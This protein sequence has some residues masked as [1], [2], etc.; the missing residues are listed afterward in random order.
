MQ[1]EEKT[2]MFYNDYALTILL[3]LFVAVI[4]IFIQ[5]FFKKYLESD[6]YYY[7]KDITL[8]AAWALCGIWASDRSL[9]IT[10]AAG[11]AA[12]CVGF[13][14]KVTKGKNL[15]FLYFIVGLGFSLFGPRIAFIEFAQGEYYYLTYFASIA[16]STLWI[17]I[18]PIFFQ[19]ID[20]IPGMCGL[21]LTVSWTLVSIVIMLSSQNLREAVQLCLIGMV[22]IL[23]FWSR[24]IHAYRRLTEPLTALWGTLFAGLSIFGV[25][26][27]VAFYTLAALP[28]GLF[29]IP[30]IETS[31]SVVS[32][33]F[34]PKPT[35]NLILYRK[36]LSKG[37]DHATAVHT[38]VV[39]CAL[40]GCSAAFIQIG[41]ANSLVLLTAAVFIF[42]ITWLFFRYAS[43][44]VRSQSRRPGLWGIR[45]D[46]ISLNY[47]ITQ[48]Q[49]SI[50][51]GTE[52][53]MIVTPDALAALR[54]RTDERY[55]NIV[56][57]ADLVLPDGAGLIAA[58]KILHTP[59]QERIP[60]VEFTE[61]ICKRAAYEGWGIWF[62]G[63]GPGTAEAAA[64]KLAEKYQGLKIAGTRN[65]YFEDD[66]TEKICRDIRESNAKILFV[67]LGVPKQEY[68]L[69]ENLD[70]SGATVG[71]GIGG[72]MDVISGKLKRAPRIWQLLC[73]EWL[74]RTI[75]EPWRW[76]RILKLPVFALYVMFTALHIDKF[77]PDRWDEDTEIN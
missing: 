45:V 25:S 69:E 28:L 27:G 34:L 48:V 22:L 10:I 29:M 24:H 43:T 38:V 19:E 13:C 26:K 70:K 32:A 40:I 61:H 63:G 14:Q 41:S 67:G 71:M 68:W 18:F 46:N 6:Q 4:C 5:K 17:G 58:L 9:K 49:H 65:G 7:L 66:E 77:N 47:A 72:T 59:I 57:N 75:Q 52:H 56:R 39:V 11:V 12:A 62:L 2:L 60:G 23:V 30:F 15:R 64:K 33:A 54:S 44:S 20:E 51:M 37:M 35:G 8:V 73:L 21:L 74:Y 50:N 55:R 53:C 36:L 76:K 31:I 42:F 16:I 3:V 1:T